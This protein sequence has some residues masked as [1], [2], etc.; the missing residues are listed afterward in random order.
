M[1]HKQT[2]KII[3]DFLAFSKEYREKKKTN[4]KDEVIWLELD[5]IWLKKYNDSMKAISEYDINK[6]KYHK[7]KKK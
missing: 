6:I 7:K 5:D 4:K 2:I 3:D 1:T